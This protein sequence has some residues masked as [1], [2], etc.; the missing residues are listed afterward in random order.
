MAD[1]A[2]SFDS[3]IHHF[4]SLPDPRHSRNRRHLLVD[5]LVIAVCGVIVG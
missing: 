3:I 2:V 5:V 1:S 4:E